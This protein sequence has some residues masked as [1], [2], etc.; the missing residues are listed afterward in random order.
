MST[1]TAQILVGQKHY[2]SGGIIPSHRLYLF[3]NSRASWLLIAED[4]SKD[5]AASNKNKIKWVPTVEKMLE[6][7]LLM[8]AMYVERDEALIKMAGS[9]FR[10]KDSNGLELYQDIKPH[11]LNKL[12]EKCRSI[13][14]NN[15]IIVSVF[16]GSTIRKQIP[17]LKQYSLDMEVCISNCIEREG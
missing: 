14:F 3:E 4:I 2:Y 6:D 11:D 12:Y 13:I 8:V 17:I 7:A 1:V 10:S 16:E 5:P 15:K 9:Y